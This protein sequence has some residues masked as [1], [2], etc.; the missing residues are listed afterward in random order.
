MLMTASFWQRLLALCIMLLLSTTTGALA[1]PHD[2]GQ[3]AQQQVDKDIPV[4]FM[5]PESV[6]QHLEA[7]SPQWLVDVR[8]RSSYDQVHLPGARS[9]PLSEFPQRFAE[10]PR[11]IPVVLY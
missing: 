9:L 8:S 1:N 4:T 5:T 10:I 2:Y 7:G 6:K 3:F 11:D